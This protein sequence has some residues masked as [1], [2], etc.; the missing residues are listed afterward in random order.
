M[1]KLSNNEIKNILRL[2]EKEEIFKHNKYIVNGEH[3][4][5]EAKSLGILEKSYS[6]IDDGYSILISQE[7]LNKLSKTSG[8]TRKIG[9]VKLEKK[10]ELSNKI[11]LLDKIQDPGNFGTLLR[12]AIAFGFN[13]IIYNKGS[14]FPYNDKVIRSSQGAIFKVN[15][16]NADLLDFINNHKDYI[17]YSTDVNNGILLSSVNKKDHKLG[18]ILGSEGSGVSFEIN[19][20]VKKHIY[21]KTINTESLN[22]AVAGSI[23]MHYFSS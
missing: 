4:V 8:N 10:E 18:I 19:N 11:I 23:I 22:V 6:I 12:S 2:Y 16:I 14:V 13:T 17:Y 15:L 20:I 5:Q 3:L 7:Q 9:I 21:I 1:N